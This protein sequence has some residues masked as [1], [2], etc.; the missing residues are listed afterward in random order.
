MK[1][2]QEKKNS[3][4]LINSSIKK[5]EVHKL[6]LSDDKSL[7][8]FYFFSFFISIRK[9]FTQIRPIHIILAQLL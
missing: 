4:H 3:F 1:D 2:Q 5:T 7:I 9:K 8:Y 6:I